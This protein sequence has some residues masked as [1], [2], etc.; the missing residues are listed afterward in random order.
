MSN[1]IIKRL[2][3]LYYFYLNHFLF[4]EKLE[5]NHNCSPF[6]LLTRS[7][8]G[9]NYLLGLLNSHTEIITYGEIFSQYNYIKWDR[10]GYPKRGKM[11]SMM[12]ENP[13]NFLE[14]IIFRTYERRV[15]A[16]GFKLFYYHAQNK[17]WQDIWHYFKARKDIKIIHLKRK[18]IL[19]THLSKERAMRTGQWVKTNRP[20]YNSVL[21]PNFKRN[22]YAISLDYEKCLRVF[23]ETRQM[24]N[25]YYS[26]FSDHKT[27]TVTYENLVIDYEKEIKRIQNFL[28]VNYEILRAST[29]KQSEQSLSSAISNY[30]DL[31]KRLKNTPWEIFFEE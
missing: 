12:Q 4:P 16:V 2:K 11:V 13:I 23:I 9:S 7:R 30:F 31:K 3:N 22:D 26:F 24:E 10:R 20:K 29:R 21:F 1:R 28:G 25:Y 19:K 6:I 27:I 15:S 17:K 5:P 14:R 18:N 8:T